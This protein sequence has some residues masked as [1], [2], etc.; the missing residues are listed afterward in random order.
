MG[1]R[2]ARRRRQPR[3]GVPHAPGNAAVAGRGAA[4]RR[5][6]TVEWRGAGL[7]CAALRRRLSRTHERGDPRAATP[8]PLSRRSSRGAGKE[9]GGA[10][11]A[12]PGE[13]SLAWPPAR[14]LV[15]ER[16]SAPRRRSSGRES[17][18]V[19]S[20]GR[21]RVGLARAVRLPASASVR[22]TTPTPSGC[23]AASPSGRPAAALPPVQVG[24]ALEPARLKLLQ[25]RA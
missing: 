10:R 13:A 11:C 18:L 20:S 5:V 9:S 14:S 6:G 8:R 12:E 16:A 23:L 21:V 19:G 2:P 3:R 24:S 22:G 25:G 17:G 4:C 1:R 7:R 15:A